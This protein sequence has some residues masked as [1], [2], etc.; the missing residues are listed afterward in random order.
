MSEG[1]SIKYGRI[2]FIILVTRTFLDKEA[3]KHIICKYIMKLE[4]TKSTP[5][6][7]FQW[8]LLRHFKQYNTIHDS[9]WKK[10]TTHIIKQ[11]RKTYEPAFQTSINTIIITGP[12]KRTKYTWLS[13]LI[14]R[15][16]ETRQYLLSCNIWPR[17]E[18]SKDHEIKAMSMHQYSWSLNRVQPST[19]AYTSNFNTAQQEVL[20][21][22][23][24][25][26]HA[27]MREI[28]Q[29]IRLGD[30]KMTR[31]VTQC[32]IPKYISC[33]ENKSKKRSHK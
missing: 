22:H 24:T 19:S 31:E 10:F 15:M 6:E 12:T 7:T 25:Y 9:G 3:H 1:I 8:E 21:L 23:E 14:R 5:M 27:D 13:T 20:R 2:F 28:Q 11:H 30:I 29:K 26:A 18:T 32:H 33:C 4:I 16:N 17:P